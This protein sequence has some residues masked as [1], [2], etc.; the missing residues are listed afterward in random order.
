ME[1]KQ[2]MIRQNS[3]S[4]K[5][6]AVLFVVLTVTAG[7]AIATSVNLKSA[8]SSTSP[9]IVVGGGNQP[10]PSA[11]ATPFPSNSPAP[12]DPG[13]WGYAQPANFIIASRTSSNGTV[14]YG[15]YNT[16]G[17]KWVTSWTS[18]NEITVT[19]NVYNNLPY[20]GKV[21]F[22]GN[23]SSV[24]SSILPSNNSITDATQA[25]FRL[26]NNVNSSLVYIP[27][28][29]TGIEIYG[30][31]WDG[32]AANNLGYAVAGNGHIFE[33]AGT[34]V[35]IHDTN[36]TNAMQYV[37][38]IDNT[39]DITIQNNYIFNGGGDDDISIHAVNRFLV[40]HN[41]IMNHTNQGRIT[42]VVHSGIELEDGCQ[43]G[44]VQNNVVWANND[45]AANTAGYMVKM[46]SGVSTPNDNIQLINN[47]A[48]GIGRY[49]YYFY[50]ETPTYLNGEV[51]VINCKSAFAN[52][53]GCY[54]TYS[55]NVV[56]YGGNF[57]NARSGG[58]NGAGFDFLSHSNNVVAYNT[59]FSGNAGFDVILEA[60][61]CTNVQLFDCALTSATPIDNSGA[62]TLMLASS[63][64]FFDFVY[65]GQAAVAGQVLFGNSSGF[66]KANSVSTT[67]VSGSIV[68]A[69][70]TTYGAINSIVLKQGDYT[71]PAWSWTVGGA[72]YVSNS[73]AG[74]LTQTMPL[75]S[76][77]VV[78]YVGYAISATTMYFDPH[79]D[80]MIVLT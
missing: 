66:F 12:V 33:V 36:A 21:V 37:F 45:T 53:A 73:T 79:P 65:E 14:Y 68:L 5:G 32:N 1:E 50:G 55:N 61:T 10:L 71:N 3:G 19:N 35:K 16:T 20:N 72:I 52:A 56:F 23:F 34:N 2:E 80:S 43:N 29:A 26:A 8:P 64:G 47:L 75:S 57:S 9:P 77:N 58:L 69:T 13:G 74:A 60:S 40:D 70:V 7:L 25:E 27:S 17:A 11:S 18:T 39:N 48:Y 59:L 15:C 42:G 54:F 62:G 78:L 46:H 4:A 63:N 51:D 22:V 67:A 6:I 49:G 38:D 41:T 44:I 76:G 31:Y 28:N 30:G 24:P